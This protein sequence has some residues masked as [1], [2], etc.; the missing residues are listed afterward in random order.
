MICCSD[1]HVYVDK[2]RPG[3]WGGGRQ[4]Q[5]G[6]RQ[7][8][9]CANKIKRNDD[10]SKIQ[11]PYNMTTTVSI[12]SGRGCDPT[13]LMLAGTHYS[14]LYRVTNVNNDTMFV[15]DK[16]GAPTNREVI[17]TQILF[18][19]QKLLHN[20]GCMGIAIKIKS[21]FNVKAKFA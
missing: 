9:Q 5:R 21:Y 1:Y 3:A 4:A 11:N 14:I 13:S 8:H 17:Y 2:A 6:G 18:A 10:L 16:S 7:A 15:A 12:V 20:T 19:L